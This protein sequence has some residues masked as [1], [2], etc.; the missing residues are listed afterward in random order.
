MRTS[1]PAV[2]R[3]RL[4]S[5]TLSARPISPVDRNNTRHSCSERPTRRFAV[6]VA[7]SRLCARA[8]TVCLVTTRHSPRGTSLRA[9]LYRA[10]GLIR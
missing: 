6:G 5:R 9:A 8:D 3:R 7:R 4:S 2:T 1:C 10:S